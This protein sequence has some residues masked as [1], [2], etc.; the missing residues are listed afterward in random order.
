MPIEAVIF[1]LDGT[2]ASFNLDY[3]T[4]RAEVKSFLNKRGVPDSVLTIKESIFEMLKKAEIFFKNASKT[5][6]VFI[7]VQKE[8][9]AIAERF[10]LEA[11][12]NTSLMPGT[13]D[14]LKAL[15]SM[16]IK[17]GLCTINSQNAANKILQRFKIAGFFDAVVPRDLV[18]NVKPN[19]E[20]FETALKMLKTPPES[21]LI[22][23]DSSTDMQSA[24]EIKAIAVGVPTGVSTMQQLMHNGANYIITSL[25]DL[26][27]LVE[28][29]NKEKEAEAKQ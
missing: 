13:N 23:G 26:P 4:L 28:K 6:E 27:L 19:S 7:E 5:D 8:A 12:A 16:N 15:K 21:T 1:D 14:A 2:L 20:H 18:R 24:K 17:I 10:E 25:G 11:A 9:L 3:K 29:I 22:I